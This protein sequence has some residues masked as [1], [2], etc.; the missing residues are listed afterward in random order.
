MSD[1]PSRS[2]FPPGFVFGAATA[3]F[4][5]EGGQGPGT[6][7]GPSIWDDMCATPGP[8]R[9]EHDGRTACDHYNRWEEDLDL[10]A[11]GNFDA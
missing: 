2:D 1:F 6:G 8:V 10:L 11:R 3:A 9:D 7:R 4:Q 5:I